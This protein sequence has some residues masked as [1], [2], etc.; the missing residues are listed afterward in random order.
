MFALRG[1]TPFLAGVLAFIAPG[2][3][4]AQAAKA[5]VDS[6]VFVTRLGSDTLVIERMVRSPRRVEAEVAMRVPRTTR[7]VYVLELS[8]SGMFERMEASTFDTTA[9]GATPAR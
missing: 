9:G 8:P 3:A 1:I 5:P 6:A 4:S 2:K 7:T